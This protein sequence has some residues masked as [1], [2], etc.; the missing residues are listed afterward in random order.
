MPT[1]KL[2]N[3]KKQ[4]RNLKKESKWIPIF[5][6]AYNNLANLYFENKEYD[7]AIEVYQRYLKIVPKNLSALY[8]L[9]II[10]YAK[11]DFNNAIL[12]LEKILEIQPQNEQI[13]NLILQIKNEARSFR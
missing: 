5:F 10:Y 11:K 6:F 12:N 9:A 1:K 3:S 13:F 4:S 2:V 7:K 8:N